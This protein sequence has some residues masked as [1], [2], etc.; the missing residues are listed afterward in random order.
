VIAQW[1]QRWFAVQDEAATRI[2]CLV[3][4]HL[5]VKHFGHLRLEEV[6]NQILFCSVIIIIIII[7]P[8]QTKIEQFV[9]VFFE[10]LELCL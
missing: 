3:R 7:Y 10:I 2:Q 8:K 6:R 4:R 1:T 9:F 5:A